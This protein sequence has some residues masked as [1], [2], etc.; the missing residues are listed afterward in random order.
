VTKKHLGAAE[1]LRSVGL[2]ADGPV[3]WGS[4]VRSRGPGVYVIELP[5]P[6]Q[7]PPIDL[8]RVRGWI[9]RVP[10]LMVDAERPTPHQLA[11]RLAGFWLPDESVVFVGR[12]TS[13]VGRRVESFYR[14]PLGDRR[15]Y[16][17]GHW[18]KTLRV[19]ERLRIWWAETDAAEEYE[20]ALLTA[21][22]EQVDGR[23]ASGL[24][25]PT[26]ILPFANLATATGE[27]KAH[28]I[29]GSVLRDDEPSRRDA[30][31]SSDRP[32]SRE[33]PSLPAAP[34]SRSGA[35]RSGT[36]RPGTASRSGPSVLG[37]AGRPR[38]LRAREAAPAKP[39]PP[40]TYLSAA[41]LEQLRAE[42]AELTQVRRPE[43]VGRIKA[44]KE[45][46]DLRENAD[47]EAARNEQSFNEGRIQALET[48]IK[49][50]VVLQEPARG[51]AV[52]L[53]STV[54][55]E[56]EGEQ[57]SYTI[58]GPT[59]ANPGEG[60]VSH[61]SPIGRAVMGRKAGDEVVVRAPRGEVRY[62]ISEVR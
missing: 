35:R 1:L 33:A 50:A 31:G 60:R 14:T 52:G 39:T 7:Q 55:L 34:A 4:P 61:V 38:H 26:V 23:A 16:A 46:G 18:L 24:H 59:E 62:R 43:I 28:G 19:L 12:S 37:T 36:A 29:A 9:E 53:G 32:A 17:G 49:T 45:L 25:D 10:T 58:V 56:R 30:V 6:T 54:V 21:F 20:D 44:A 51:E 15:P 22:A 27:R 40:P 11:A 13:S 2:L 47:Y 8:A 42:L 41:G 5:A 3:L 57:E 48:L